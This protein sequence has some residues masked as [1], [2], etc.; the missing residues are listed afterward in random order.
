MLLWHEVCIELYTCLSPNQEKFNPNIAKSFIVLNEVGWVDIH[1]SCLNNR[2]TGHRYLCTL[3]IVI[4]STLGNGKTI[5]PP[6]LS[7]PSL[8]STP[9]RQKPRTNYKYIWFISSCFFFRDDW[10][11]MAVKLAPTF[12]G[13][14]STA[15]SISL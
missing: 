8:S 11:P 2:T 6:V 5:C 9:L 15:A 3:S 7:D 1:I 14:R 13:L 10:Y 4:I 12:A